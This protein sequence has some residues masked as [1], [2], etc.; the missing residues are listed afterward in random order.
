M[1]TS[2]PLYVALDTLAPILQQLFVH[3]A[4]APPAA[5]RLPPETPERTGS[6]VKG[7]SPRTAAALAAWARTPG[8]WRCN[9]SC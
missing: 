9:R 1:L 7:G 8:R 4:T 6:R 3:F 2:H 5:E